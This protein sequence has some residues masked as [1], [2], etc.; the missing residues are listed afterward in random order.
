MTI[1]LIVAAS[2]NNVIGRNNQLPWY[3]PGDLRYFKAMTL[4]KPVIM[5]R[6][7]FESIGKPLPGRDN[8]VITRQKDYPAE[9]IKLVSSLDEAIILGESINLINGGDEVMVIGGAQ[10]YAEALELADRVYLTRVHDHVEGDA[11]FPA[12]E[13]SSWHESGRE[14]ILAKEPNPFDFS[15]LV[16]DR[17]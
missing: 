2:E 14:D 11:Y 16:L 12:L 17:T 10:I 6:K 1:A 8:I 7:T 5:G 13:T 15:Y 3:L 9:G 4:G